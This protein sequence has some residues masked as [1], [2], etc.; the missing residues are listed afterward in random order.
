MKIADKTRVFRDFSIKK[1]LK[2][3]PLAPSALANACRLPQTEGVLKINLLVRVC[4]HH[5][6]RKSYE[7][8]KKRAL[9]DSSVEDRSNF[10]C[11]RTFV[12]FYRYKALTTSI[13]RESVRLAYRGKVI[14][15]KRT[16]A[17]HG[18]SIKISQIFCTT[19]SA[20]LICKCVS[21]V[22][23]EKTR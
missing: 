16:R 18:F 22:N 7:R 8:R 2:F 21:S 6:S 15:A 1:L 9:R 12:I 13:L 14:G 23:L 17:F 3:S 20:Q 19:P 4:V 10:L 5:A 11:A